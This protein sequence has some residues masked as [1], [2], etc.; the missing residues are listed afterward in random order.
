MSK[1][2]LGSLIFA[3]KYLHWQ[4]LERNVISALWQYKAIGLTVFLHCSLTG[5]TMP[6]KYAGDLAIFTGALMKAFLPIPQTTQV[7]TR[8]LPWRYYLH[9]ISTFIILFLRQFFK[10]DHLVYWIEIAIRLYP[11]KDV[12]LVV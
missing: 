4:Y 6:Q 1:G 5:K 7:Y 2:P 8:R 9:M 10:V 11:W 12:V 3:V